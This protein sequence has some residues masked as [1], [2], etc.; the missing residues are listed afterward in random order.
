MDL[1]EDIADAEGEHDIERAARAGEERDFLVAE[2][3]GAVG[4]GGRT[5]RVGDPA[6]RAR[7]AVAARIRDAIRRIEAVHPALGRHL[8][9]SVQTGTFCVYEPEHPVVWHR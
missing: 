8:A 2:L 4:L 5:R 7:K 1:E 9:H 6:E 3:T